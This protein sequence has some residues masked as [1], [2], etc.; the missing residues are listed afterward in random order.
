MYD[1][2]ASQL[3]PPSMEMVQR[4]GKSSLDQE[5]LNIP[6][7]APFPMNSNKINPFPRGHI[8]RSFILYVHPPMEK[9]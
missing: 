7:P 5:F 8:C 2:Q 4:R 6:P 1:M 3:E 9:I